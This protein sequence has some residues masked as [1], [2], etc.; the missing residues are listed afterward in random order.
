MC[1]WQ[2][3]SNLWYPHSILPLSHYTYARNANYVFVRLE[4]DGQRTPLYIG[5]SEDLAKELLGH[6]KLVPAI[7][8]GGNELHV[9]LLAQSKD[10][11]LRV[12]TDIRNGHHTPLN[13]QSSLAGLGRGPIN[14][15]GLYDPSNLFK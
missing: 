14:P 15:F 9:H 12:E 2:G 3:V 1:Y 5:Q 7:M 8:L 11:R 6:P 13:E 10:E 4:R